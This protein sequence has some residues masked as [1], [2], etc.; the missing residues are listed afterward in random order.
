MFQ[1][2]KCADSTERGS[3]RHCKAHLTPF[4]PANPNTAGAPE[5][6]G[7]GEAQSEA[8]A[9]RPEERQGHQ[10]RHLRQLPGG[11]RPAVLRPLSCSLP[12]P[13]LVSPTPDA[14]TGPPG[15][16]AA[17]LAPRVELAPPEA[18]VN[19]A[20]PGCSG[21]P[22]F[23]HPCPS[24]R[25][26][27]PCC[28]LCWLSLRACMNESRLQPL[29]LKME[30]RLSVFTIWRPRCSLSAPAAPSCRLPAP[31]SALLR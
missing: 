10:P 26:E 6:R 24:L 17:C 16:H 14:R 4:P 12:P 23:P 27:P 20:P 25:P 9:R 29:L 1:P 2:S 8:G 5:V 31:P 30:S 22:S 3:S 18:D 13:V 19:A 15:Q 11:G 28:F 21:S 7:G